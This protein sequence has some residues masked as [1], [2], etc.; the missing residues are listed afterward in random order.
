MFT[1]DVALCYTGH[2]TL[3]AAFCH[4]MFLAAVTREPPSALFRLDTELKNFSA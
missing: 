4:F 3:C 1:S 2:R